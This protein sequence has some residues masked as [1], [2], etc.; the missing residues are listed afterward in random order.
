MFAR[1]AISCMLYESPSIFNAI[2]NL[3]ADRDVLHLVASS[4]G[5]TVIMSTR[6][7]TSKGAR[8]L[9]VVSA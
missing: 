3:I 6:T 2:E 9:C 4:I 5:L 1:R 8:A 7:E